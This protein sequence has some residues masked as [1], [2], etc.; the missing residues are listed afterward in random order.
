MLTL[1][2]Q[3]RTIA[4][5]TLA[6][7]VVFGQLNKIA[8]GIVLVFGSSYPDGRAGRFLTGLIVIAIAAAVT[9]FAV[10]ASNAAQAGPGWENHLAGAAVFVAVVGLV[11]AVVLTIGSVANN[12]AGIP[13]GYGVNIFF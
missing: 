8:V 3:A 1:T 12:D 6:V 2:P 9:F 13:G 4:A 7:L 11:I 5:F 10:Q